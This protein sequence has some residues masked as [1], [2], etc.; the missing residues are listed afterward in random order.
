MQHDVRYLKGVG[1]KRAALLGKLEI[2]TAED[3]LRFY[4]RAYE[5]R[6]HIVPID[7]LEDGQ[8]ACVT[9]RVLGRAVP[10]R[11][12][13][14][15]IICKVDAADDT[16]VLHLVFFNAK[17]LKLDADV[18]Y[19]FYGRAERQG[20]MITM[21]NPVYEKISEDGMI[22]GRILPVYHLTAGIT[23]RQMLRMVQQ[24]LPLAQS[25]PD[26]VP[27]S[28]RESEGLLSLPDALRAVHEPENAAHLDAGRQALG[29]EELFLLS[30]GLGSIKRERGFCGQPI[31]NVDLSVFAHALPFTLT[32]AQQRCI[33]EA[34]TDMTTPGTPMRRLIQGDVGS[35]KTVIAAACI[36][37]VCKNGYQSA[38]MAPTE[39]L[40]RQHAQDLS[41]LLEP[42]GIRTV[43][44]TGS[45]PAAAA[46]ETRSA[47]AEGTADLIIGTHAL[48]SD[49][50]VYR[51]LR[52]VVTDE[53]HRFGVRQ[54]TILREKGRADD[55]R[56]HM[57]VMSATPI[58]RTMA[59]VI[60]GDM[61]LSIVD[62]LP[63]GRLPV[64]TR[65]PDESK[66][67]AVYGFMRKLF[68]RGRQGYV[69]CPMIDENETDA[70]MH[71]VEQYALEL[72]QEV[73]PEFKVAF[74]HGRM[75]ASEKDEIMRAFADGE[76]TLLVS[77]TVIE[78]GVNVPNAAIMLVENAER[79]G[80]SQLHQLRGRVGR[81]QWQSYCVLMS[82]SRSARERLEAMCRTNDGFEI[83]REDLRL[84]GP[85]DFFGYRQSGV[86]GLQIAQL[87]ADMPLLD[88][89]H[90]AAQA[91][92]ASDEGLTRPEHAALRAKL[93]EMFETD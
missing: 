64:D 63:P 22:T 6:S 80:L 35:G 47:I 70:Q 55:L 21:T 88:R 50:A 53:Q 19:C 41:V 8:T 83:A 52:L 10:F 77:T 54:R 81:G 65:A 49:S 1:E 51:N 33:R 78:V 31:A 68:L 37:A 73:F 92:L 57:L 72:Q 67:Q 56:P 5:D 30:A 26:P 4:P 20:R 27:A 84:R 43:L 29:F 28:V 89:A 25:L 45:M 74:L 12:R 71:S 93:N 61:D 46:R 11:A 38:L 15:M 86:P 36:Y 23:N 87:G 91:V 18:D 13:T 90:R 58:P 42:M 69:V 40:A 24:A 76:T 62:E 14:G 9:A 17:Y 60:Y 34:M 44:L 3:L 75:K 85:G 39:I 48:L 66:R 82:G 59:M 32:N 2:R 7:Q 79:F 16:G